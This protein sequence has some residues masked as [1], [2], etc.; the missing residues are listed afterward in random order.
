MKKEKEKST[1]FPQPNCGSERKTERLKL[2]LI[3]FS[4]CVESFSLLW[5]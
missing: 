3:I 2:I 5:L 4:S 1:N